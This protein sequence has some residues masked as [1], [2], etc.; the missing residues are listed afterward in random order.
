MIKTWVQDVDE[1]EAQELI[2]IITIRNQGRIPKGS[3]WVTGS[4]KSGE[5]NKV[6]IYFEDPTGKEEKS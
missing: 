4:S 1:S 2:E 3:K 6:G 5:P